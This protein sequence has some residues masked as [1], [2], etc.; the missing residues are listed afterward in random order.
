MTYTAYRI[1]QPTAVQLRA[2]AEHPASRV[3]PFRGQGRDRDSWQGVLELPADEVRDL[4]DDL[5][6]AP[7]WIAE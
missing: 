6:L 4:L 1:V 2:L 5:E 3:E 7:F